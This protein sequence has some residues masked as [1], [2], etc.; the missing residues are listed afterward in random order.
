MIYRDEHNNNFTTVSNDIIRSDLSD[1][2]KVLLLFMLSCNDDW[3]FSLKGLSYSLELSERTVSDRLSE[4]KQAGYI[5]QKRSK[6][7]KGQ[8]DSCSWNVYE[9]PL[10]T[11]Q[12]N[13]T[14]EKVRYGENHTAEKPHRGE[15][16]VKK[17][18]V[19]KEIPIVRN[20]NNKEI[21]KRVYGEFSHVLLSDAEFEKL[22]SR[23][24]E[25]V[26]DSYITK[27]DR[28]IENYPKKGNKYKSHYSTILTWHDG[29]QK[30]TATSQPITQPKRQFGVNEDEFR[31]LIAE[32]A[33]KR[34][35]L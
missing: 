12:K 9:N 25:S 8:F 11:P 5:R 35:E 21:P 18:A 13:H 3:N 30:R 4:L 14:V 16:T 27:L 20:T 32:E 6:N 19:I 7:Q 22:T 26:R 17:T 2:A 33:R 24:G 10:T 31:Q 1:G 23:F 15:T 28:Y 34:G 29:D